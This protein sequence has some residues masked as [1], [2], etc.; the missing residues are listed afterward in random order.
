M[1]SEKYT[2]QKLVDTWGSWDIEF[3]LPSYTEPN[4]KMWGFNI[5]GMSSLM[6]PPQDVI[7]LLN[8]SVRAF[9]SEKV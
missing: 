4:L 7:D 9:G 2:D 8:H 5:T 1:Q 3:L 6:A